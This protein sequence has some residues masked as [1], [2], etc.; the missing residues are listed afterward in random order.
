MLQ[1]LPLR[2][3]YQCHKHFAHPPT[4]AAEAAHNLPKVVLELVGLHLQLCTLYRAPGSYG[5]E[6]LEGFFWALYRVA[7][8][9]MRWLPC[10]L[11]KVSTTRCAGLTNPSSIAVAA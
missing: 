5:R 3:A 9:L 10:S 1:Q 6:E 8:S 7:A 11:G 2:L 4:L